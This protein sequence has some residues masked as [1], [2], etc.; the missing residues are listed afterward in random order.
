MHM[1]PEI[2]E[3]CAA[4]QNALSGNLPAMLRF[5]CHFLFTQSKD[6]RHPEWDAFFARACC[7]TVILGGAYLGYVSNIEAQ[8]RVAGA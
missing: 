6:Y 7:E 3:N 8:I 5:T 2:A 4:L 1:R